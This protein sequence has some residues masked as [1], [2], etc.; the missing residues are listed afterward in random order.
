MPR[1]DPEHKP[2]TSNRPDKQG[3]THA[4]C[5]FHSCR[6]L[7]FV[8]R[9]SGSSVKLGEHSDDRLTRQPPRR[10]R[11]GGFFASVEADSGCGDICW[12]ETRAASGERQCEVRLPGVFKVLLCLPSAANGIPSDRCKTSP[13]QGSLRRGGR[14]STCLVSG[15]KMAPRS[16][17]RSMLRRQN[18][19]V[20]T[21]P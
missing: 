9:K 16:C 14:W 7:N 20:L 1:G 4:V 5:G 18:S 15:W 8:P 10:W 12:P 17:G 13:C 21:W 2:H 19:K 11:E 3:E 6:T